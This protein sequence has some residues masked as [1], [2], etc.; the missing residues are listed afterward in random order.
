MC[1]RVK[2]E[3]SR[4]D[5]FLYRTFLYL[6]I[7][8]I[9]LRMYIR[10]TNESVACDENIPDFN[11]GYPPEMTSR[12][13][14]RQVNDFNGCK[15]V[16]KSI[17]LT[18]GKHKNH[19]R[20]VIQLLRWLYVCIFLYT[21]FLYSSLCLHIDVASLRVYIAINYYPQLM[22]KL[23]VMKSYRCMKHQHQKN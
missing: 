5:A 21:T 19:I 22:K 18:L 17:M 1:I 8:T 6:N 11:H 3:Q 9:N 7:N 2:H 13:V 12:K 14:T 23:F 4:A 10:I 15:L 16:L 20:Y